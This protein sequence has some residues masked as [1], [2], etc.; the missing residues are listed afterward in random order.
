[1]CLKKVGNQRGEKIRGASNLPASGIAHGAQ[2]LDEKRKQTHAGP[3]EKVVNMEKSQKGKDEPPS[4]GHRD[5]PRRP[6]M[7][8]KVLPHIAD[9]LGDGIANKKRLS[10]SEKLQKKP[11]SVSSEERPNERPALEGHYRTASASKLPRE[12]GKREKS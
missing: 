11:S 4:C 8:R 12:A 7:T 1:M 6:A 10:E 9:P 5:A 3:G 2:R